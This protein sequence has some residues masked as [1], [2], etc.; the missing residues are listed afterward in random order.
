[1]GTWTLGSKFAPHAAIPSASP[2]S[3]SPSAQ[4]TPALPAPRALLQRPFGAGGRNLP[5][6]S[7]LAA[8]GSPGVPGERIPASACKLLT[9]SSR[10]KRGEKVAE[11]TP[12]GFSPSQLFVAGTDEVLPLGVLKPRGTDA[13]CEG[14]SKAPVPRARCRHG[15]PADDNRTNT[16]FA[17]GILSPRR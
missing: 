7:P 10:G 15:Y 16:C 8:H 5:R 14:F 17:C 9:S 13:G 1:M 6:V 2:G 4:Q 12:R 11:L 3:R